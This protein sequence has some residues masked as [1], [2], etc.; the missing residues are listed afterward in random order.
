MVIPFAVDLRF[1][2]HGFQGVDAVDRFNQKGLV[3]CAAGEAFVE[4]R[5]QQW[6]DQ[7]GNDEVQRQGQHHHQGQPA[8]VHKHHGDKHHREQHIQ[9]QGDGVAGEEAADVF[10]LAHPRH[11]IADA[12]RLEVGQRQGH[13]MAEQPR[14]Q[15]DVD[16]T[17][18]VGEHVA[19]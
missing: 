16:A 11:R 3:L 8:A 14:A 7:Q 5:A 15:F 2:C 10:Q 12:T 4:A 1:H 17:G 6:G 19:A 18:G 13:Q 9:Q